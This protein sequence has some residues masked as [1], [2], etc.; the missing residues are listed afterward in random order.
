MT[1]SFIFITVWLIAVII[2]AL[3]YEEPPLSSKIAWTPATESPYNGKK[4]DHFNF[5]ELAMWMEPYMRVD[6][7]CLWPG[8]NWRT[9]HGLIRKYPL[10]IPKVQYAEGVD[11]YNKDGIHGNSESHKQDIR[12]FEKGEKGHEDYL[13]PSSHF[14]EEHLTPD[15]LSKKWAYNILFQ[16]RKDFTLLPNISIKKAA[17]INNPIFDRLMNEYIHPPTMSEVPMLPRRG[18]LHHSAVEGID[19]VTLP[20]TKEYFNFITKAYE[21]TSKQLLIPCWKNGQ[22]LI[23]KPFPLWDPYYRVR[24]K[25]TLGFSGLML[26]MN[27]YTG[28]NIIYDSERT[29][30][31]HPY[32]A[33]PGI[34]TWMQG[35]A[36]PKDPKCPKP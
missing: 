31:F 8:H 20:E 1:F 34:G 9:H 25:E 19:F 18:R 12:V 3:T 13:M 27:S 10:I 35:W 22:G 5:D 33:I 30:S 28:F 24:K 6:R 4:L 26:E 29:F 32:R 17:N 7:E 14:F 23:C 15:D 36:F 11:P 21:E 2:H 16:A